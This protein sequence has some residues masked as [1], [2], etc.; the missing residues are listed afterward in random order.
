MFLV[1][2]DWSWL[3]RCSVMLLCVV[4]SVGYF[5]LVFCIWFLL[6]MCWLVVISGVMC[7]VGW[8][9][10]IVMSLIFLIGW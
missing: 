3:M 1:L 5:V 6:N 9:L 4:C 10:F 2:F 8:V 7:L